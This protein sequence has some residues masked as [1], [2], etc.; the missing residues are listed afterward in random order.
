MPLVS[1]P[2]PQTSE[3]H[4]SFDLSPVEKLAFASGI[5][6]LV[7]MALTAKQRLFKQRFLIDI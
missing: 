5:M 7:H 2:L 4:I 3:V 1:K 6:R